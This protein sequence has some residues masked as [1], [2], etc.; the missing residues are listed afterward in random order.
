VFNR[1]FIVECDASGA[2]ISA[3]LHQGTEP[4]AFF[5]HLLTLH[6]YKLT[7]YECEL[8]G[9]VQAMHHW[10]PYL[11]G[12]TFLIQTYHCSLKF[13]LDQKLSMI[14]QHQW[15]SKLM[16]FDFRVEYQ[17]GSTNIVA[18]ALSSRDMADGPELAALSSPSFAVFDSLR[19]EIAASPIL[20]QVKTEVAD[21]GCGDDWRIVDGLITVKGKDFVPH[22][23]V[24]IADILAHA[25][26]AGHEGIEKTWHRLRLD[27]H[28]PG[29]RTA[30]RDFVCACLVCQW[31]KTIQ[32]QPAGLLQP[33]VV[34]TMVCCN[35]WWYLPWY[36]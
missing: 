5:S 10:C 12:M 32:L 6:H 18:D 17:L 29:A 9:L 2:G 14:P 23:S 13:L 36:G 21:G 11:L 4:V 1:E 8:I 15:A 35:R 3:V 24:F 27:F 16:G 33:L 19:V 7:V 30:V 31:N 20:Q 22:D 26:G 34:P 28:V 25:Y